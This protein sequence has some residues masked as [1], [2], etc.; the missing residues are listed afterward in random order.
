MKKFVVL[1]ILIIVTLLLAACAPAARLRLPL[2]QLQSLRR[3]SPLEWPISLCAAHISLVCP[4]PFRMK[5][6]PTPILKSS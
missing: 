3:K 6:L 5:H 2:L 4:K 1:N